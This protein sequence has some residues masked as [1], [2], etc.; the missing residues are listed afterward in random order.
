M[1]LGRSIR[2]RLRRLRDRTIDKWTGRDAMERAAREQADAI[3]RAQEEEA[4][5]L[6]AEEEQRKREQA[7]RDQIAKDQAGLA[8]EN[9]SNNSFEESG[10]SGVI[11]DTSASEVAPGI[12][13][14]DE[15]DKMRKA[16]KRFGK[17]KR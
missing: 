8:E 11:V 4:A 5:R 12:S 7:Y 6:K 3:R 13:D 14:T 15:E 16:L 17:T 10:M 9:L 2:R 1:G